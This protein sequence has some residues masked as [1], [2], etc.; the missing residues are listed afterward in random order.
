MS[1]IRVRMTNFAPEKRKQQMTDKHF[2][3]LEF[4]SLEQFLSHVSYNDG[5]VAIIDSLQALPA[6]KALRM[7]I[8]AV[9]LCE[10]GQLQL[11][12]NGETAVAFEDEILFCPASGIVDNIIVSRNFQC[13][14]LCLTDNILKNFILGN[15]QLLHKAVYVK[16]INIIPLDHHAKQRFLNFYAL[17]RQEM[18]DTAQPY[19]KQMMQSLVQAFLYF[20]CG[21]VQKFLEKPSG[22]SDHLPNEETTAADYGETLFLRF[23][24]L[25]ANDEVKHHPVD[26]YADKLCITPK[27]LTIICNRKSHKTASDWIRDYTLDEVRYYLRNTDCTIKEIASRME[28]SS[29]QSFGKYVRQHMG[30]SPNN[31]RNRRKKF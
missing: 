26:Y 11:D 31:Y 5:D 6:A 25:L 22:R 15:A 10:K 30:V 20:L 17:A 23:L 21:Q 8:H 16:R 14:L 28:F 13:K 24:D 29:V 4:S 18:T 27:Y 19:H 1:R 3:A 9:L 12:V 7:G 2:T